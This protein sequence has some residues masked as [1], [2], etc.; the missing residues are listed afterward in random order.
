MGRNAPAGLPALTR[1]EV[2]SAI[3]EA[4]AERLSGEKNLL[5][6]LDEEPVIFPSTFVV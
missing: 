1:F 3:S 6:A 5:S 4:L 2:P